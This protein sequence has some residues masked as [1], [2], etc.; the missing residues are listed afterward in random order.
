MSLRSPRSALAL[1]ALLSLPTIFANL[2]CNRKNPAEEG[3]SH[4]DDDQFAYT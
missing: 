4:K 2:P 3:I 1:L